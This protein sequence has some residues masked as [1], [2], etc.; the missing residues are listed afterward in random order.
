MS[1]SSNYLMAVQSPLNGAEYDSEQP[2]VNGQSH[3]QQSQPYNI[4]A[5]TYN[6]TPV[7]VHHS[8]YNALV[9][10]S[11]SPTASPYQQSQSQSQP[12]S[13]GTITNMKPHLITRSNTISPIGD[14]TNNKFGD[15]R[16]VIPIIVGTPNSSGTQSPLEPYALNSSSSQ[17]PGICNSSPVSISCHTGPTARNYNPPAFAS[18]SMQSSR[19]PATP[20]NTLSLSQSRISSPSA[21]VTPC[22]P[23]HPF[24]NNISNS[25]RQMS[26][27]MSQAICQ[28]TSP[29]I[30]VSSRQGLG[31]CTSDLRMV[32]GP[33]QALTSGYRPAVQ[34]N[35]TNS[36]N[37]RIIQPG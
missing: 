13:A 37:N 19:T 33:P 26:Q 21:P 32:Q 29:I 16:M 3:W 27:N 1:S 5:P 15:N 4:P 34:T 25:G 10:M 8:S 30:L 36:G 23:P 18:S 22:S 31:P 35:Y 24:N 9:Q 12:L 14:T 6:H 2:T 28:T 7:L 17:T 11:T 20:N